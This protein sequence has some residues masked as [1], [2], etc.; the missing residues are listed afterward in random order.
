MF[1]FERGEVE[2]LE[3]RVEN[4]CFPPEDAQ[5][6]NTGTSYPVEMD[7]RRV[8]NV[9]QEDNPPCFGPSTTFGLRLKVID[10]WYLVLQSGLVR[11]SLATALNE[12]NPLTW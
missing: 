1:G 12:S 11:H 5:R 6:V 7:I 4:E 8:R 9:I 10:R 2:L 3:V